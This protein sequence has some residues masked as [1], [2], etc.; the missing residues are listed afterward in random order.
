MN[1]IPYSE[2]RLTKSD[3]KNIIISAKKGW[4]KNH[5]LFIKKFE[6]DFKK[7]LAPNML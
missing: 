2:A 6:Q 7:K 4:G 5:N 1:Y 3:L